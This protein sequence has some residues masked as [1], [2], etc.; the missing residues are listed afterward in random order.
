MTL[1]EY[2]RQQQ[3][4]EVDLPVQQKKTSLEIRQ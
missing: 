3:N 2:A 1:E 4:A